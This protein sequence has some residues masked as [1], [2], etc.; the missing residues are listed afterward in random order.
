MAA[1]PAFHAGDHVRGM[2]GVSISEERQDAFAPE[3]TYSY[4]RA[5]IGSSVAAFHAG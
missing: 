1:H 2:P 3:R 4:R 5:S